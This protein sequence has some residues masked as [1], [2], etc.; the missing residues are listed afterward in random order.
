MR[1]ARGKGSTFTHPGRDGTRFRSMP[2]WFALPGLPSGSSIPPPPW[3]SPCSAPPWPRSWR[4]REPGPINVAVGGPGHRRGGRVAGL[5]RRDER[6]GRPGT[7]RHPSTREATPGGE[8]SASAALWIAAA[9]LG[10]PARRQQPAGTGVPR[11]S[12][13]GGER[14]GARL[15]PVAV[16]DA[17]VGGPV[18]GQLRDPAACGSG[19]ASGVPIERVAPAVLLVAPF[20]A[21]AHL[22]NTLRDFDSDAALG[23]RCLAQ[24]LGSDQPLSGWR[25]P[26]PLGVAIG[27][28]LGF[29]LT[30]QLQ[31]AQRRAR[32][33]RPARHPPRSDRCRTGCGRACSWPRCCGRWPGDWPAGRLPVRR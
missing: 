11:W 32:R 21:A 4:A 31:A 24:V 9:G 7:G 30:A 13:R 3:P 5:H 22:A 23:S 17:A 10:A 18:P 25:W 27:V 19:S 33:A 6:P 29:A 8:L 26:W 28:A 12:R 16:A 15:Q 14:F 20:A 1:A 2:G